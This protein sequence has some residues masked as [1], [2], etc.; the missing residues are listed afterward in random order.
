MS[1]RFPHSFAGWLIALCILAA[2]GCVPLVAGFGTQRL[3]VEVLTVFS[4][5]MAWN[6]LAGFGGMVVVGQHVFVGVGAYG[7]FVLS[8]SWDINPWYALLAAPLCAAVF[9]VVTAWPMFRLSGA[10]FAVGTWVL[11]ELV[12]IAVL[13]TDSLGAGGGMPLTTL[14][15]MGRSERNA[16]VYWA[17]LAV[18]ALTVLTARMLLGSRLGLALT[19]VRD[20]ES[21]AR[22]SGV[23]VERSKW[24]LWVIAAAMTGAAG[25]VAYMNTLQVTPDAS[26]GLTWTATAIFISVLGGIGRMEGPFIGTLVYFLL[27]EVLGDFG[28]WYFVAL[29]CLAIATMLVSPGGA[30]SL[31]LRR[32]PQLDPF[33]IRRQMP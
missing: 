26:F 17:A 14:G 10:Q 21:A 7:L 24:L 28:A 27:R 32:W 2:L 20:S 4:I 12:R 30:W 11:A 29:G 5:A 18:A 9:A 15:S 3:L 25:A 13:N 6:L 8:N 23:G 19:S 33:C 22:A 31:L 1:P 16:G